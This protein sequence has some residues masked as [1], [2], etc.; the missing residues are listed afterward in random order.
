MSATAIKERPRTHPSRATQ[1]TRAGVGNGTPRRPRAPRAGSATRL[2]RV[3]FRSAMTVEDADRLRQ[4]IGMHVHLNRKHA[5]VAPPLGVADLAPDSG[6]FLV[7]GEREDEWSLEGR[8]WG[9]PSADLV[10]AW[11]LRAT[12]AAQLIDPETPRRDG[13]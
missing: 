1:P 13:A 3:P 7:R 2:F 11:E 10:R 6:L 8:T 4:A 9:S 12:Y 5:S